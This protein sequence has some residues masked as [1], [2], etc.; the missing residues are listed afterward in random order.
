MH[1]CVHPSVQKLFDL[2]LVD[3]ASTKVASVFV[4]NPLDVY[5]AK[6]SGDKGV[7]TSCQ[8]NCSLCEIYTSHVLLA[9]PPQWGLALRNA[10]HFAFGFL[11]S[12]CIFFPGKKVN[13][14]SVFSPR[15]SPF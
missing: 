11:V 10:Y 6:R 4:S 5:F 8:I 1:V 2:D 14:H 7:A 13:F 12:D 15:L 9:V 3:F